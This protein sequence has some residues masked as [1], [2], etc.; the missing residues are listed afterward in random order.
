MQ[1]GIFATWAK[2][3]WEM[4]YNVM[5]IT[6]GDKGPPIPTG[7]QEWAERR[8][9][10][11]VIDEW[12]DFFPN[13]NIA[14]ICGKI[15]GSV[16][17]ID[18]D[19]PEVMAIAPISESNMARKNSKGIGLHFKYINHKNIP[20]KD[21]YDLLC[22]ARYSLLP[23]SYIIEKGTTYNWVNETNL[24]AVDELTEL[25][26]KRLDK[27]IIEAGKFYVPNKNK[28]IRVDKEIPCEGGRNNKINT[29]AYAK[30]ADIH[31]LGKD[32]DECIDEIIEYD[33][34]WHSPAWL[35]DPIEKKNHRD[36]PR[37]FLKKMLQRHLKK[38]QSEKSNSET[39]I[40][41]ELAP[42]ELERGVN[43]ERDAMIEQQAGAIARM[44]PPHGIFDLFNQECERTSNKR[45]PVMNFAAA[46]AL[47]TTLAANKLRY[48]RTWP[49]SYI[50][51]LAPSGAGKN[52]PQS[53]IK[54]IL[55]Q[56]TDGQKLMGASNYASARAFIGYLTVKR[57]RLDLVDEATELFAKM[58]DCKSSS[59]F[60]GMK[61]GFLRMYSD[62][63]TVMS[64]IAAQTAGAKIPTIHN[65][66]VSVLASG[67]TNAFYPTLSGELIQQG[68]LARWFT[69]MNPAEIALSDELA[70]LPFGYG[71]TAADTY[72][73][74]EL[75][76][77]VEVWTTGPVKQAFQ[78]PT[79][80]G[81]S[82]AVD[83]E[84]ITYDKNL[85]FPLSIEINRELK[86]LEKRATD[87]G[88][89]SAPSYARAFEQ[90]NKLMLAYCVSQGT[91]EI[92]P[93]IMRW[94]YDLWSAQFNF[95]RAE[96]ESQTFSSDHTDITQVEK[97]FNEFAKELKR[98]NSS[99]AT[100][101]VD[102]RALCYR[103]FMRELKTTAARNMF[104]DAK[105]KA[106]YIRQIMP[107]HER[108]KGARKQVVFYL[109]EFED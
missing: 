106:G 68:F 94:A 42:T 13:C 61:E 8:M 4:G 51:S 58:K 19:N 3:Y 83:A 108:E 76:D 59:P 48:N 14:M 40:E 99:V 52:N 38:F 35:E 37:G 47:C 2:K 57:E 90:M 7:W 87:A 56:A 20:V 53:M 46:F 85:I 69:F 6:H 29:I 95:V 54:L 28:T 77:A 65:P 82:W 72:I 55:S 91:R 9:P 41:I 102:H 27:W 105:Q 80:D 45:T 103:Q 30:A 49:N 17:D 44:I 18:T 93:E 63:S 64:E 31:Y 96:L 22:F 62:S 73:K 34:K 100:V 11:E 60:F 25:D 66:C 43:S 32:L 5:P 107:A 79:P 39:Y 92:T 50:V 109:D 81:A 71:E 10:E 86:R 104:L 23:P 21:V 101:S 97:K 12:V 67:V 78:V 84:N 1:T 98:K 16:L 89:L 36:D 88:H 33:K 24:I 26:P 74:K 15:S 75:I 70:G